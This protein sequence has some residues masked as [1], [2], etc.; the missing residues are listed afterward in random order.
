MSGA[1]SSP[2]RAVR[3]HHSTVKLDAA[4]QVKSGTSLKRRPFIQTASKHHH[5]RAN[6]Q[7]E[8]QAYRLQ[9]EA[10]ESLELALPRED[11]SKEARRVGSTSM[12]SGRSEAALR[13]A[14]AR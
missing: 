11:V 12:R 8:S 6:P 14:G 9:H 3:Q 7:R 13:P 4:E 1:A 2:M 5:H 10:A